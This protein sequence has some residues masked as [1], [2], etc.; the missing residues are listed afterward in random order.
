M[1]KIDPKLK[2]AIGRLS[3]TPYLK[4]LLRMMFIETRVLQNP[5]RLPR[6]GK[7]S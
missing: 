3:A 4:A 7:V 6:N 2:E 1:I 5:E